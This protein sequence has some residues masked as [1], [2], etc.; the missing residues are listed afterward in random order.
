MDIAGLEKPWFCAQFFYNHVEMSQKP[1][2]AS[3][4]KVNA[5]CPVEFWL[6]CTRVNSQMESLLTWGLPLST[7]KRHLEAKQ[8]QIIGYLLLQGMLLKTCSH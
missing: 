5:T 4:I 3:P 2:A 7:R 1:E 6:L 8:E